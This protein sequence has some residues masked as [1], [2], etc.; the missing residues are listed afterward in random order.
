MD[1]HDYPINELAKHD[2]LLMI[3][4]YVCIPNIDNVLQNYFKE[5]PK[6]KIIIINTIFPN[7]LTQISDLCREI[8]VK[9]I[10]NENWGKALT[11]DKMIETSKKLNRKLTYDIIGKSPLSG[12]DEYIMTLE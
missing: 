6:G 4:T 1:L 10:F 3:Q 2:I 12:A 8:I 7:H 5:N 9:G 11:L